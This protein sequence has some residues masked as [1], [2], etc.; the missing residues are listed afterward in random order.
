[1]S[2]T[3]CCF[4]EAASS[5]ARSGRSSSNTD[6]LGTSI[7]G[8]TYV[9]FFRF[10]SATS[11]ADFSSTGTSKLNQASTPTICSI[12]VA[13]FCSGA[14]SGT[15]SGKTSGKASGTRT[16]SPHCG[17]LTRRPANAIRAFSRFAQF[18]HRN[19]RIC[20]LPVDNTSL[21]AIQPQAAIIPTP[22]LY[23]TPQPPKA[24]AIAR[25]R[26]LAGSTYAV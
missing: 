4:A 25:D 15:S 24:I 14:G 8:G 1:M 19:S 20:G 26:H 10:A 17:H 6:R 5:S 7:D 2:V 3:V 23:C 9:G 11:L 12:A 22:Q 13:W 21:F 18:G 16:G